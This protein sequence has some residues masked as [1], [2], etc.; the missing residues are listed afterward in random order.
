[1]RADKGAVK[2]FIQLKLKDFLYFCIPKR[3]TE[4]K[5]GILIYSIFFTVMILAVS[6]SNSKNDKVNSDIVHNEATADG[7]ETGNGP[8]I[9]F[10]KTEHDFGDIMDGEKVEYAFKFTNTGNKDLVITSH[11]ATC[12]CTVPEYPKGAIAPGDGGVIKVAF[13]SKGKKGRNNKEIRISTN[14]SERDVTLTIKAN[15]IKP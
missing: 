10:E 11:S 7:D 14:A 3:K 9:S 2:E 5:P 1:L 15:V 12:G 6:C 8:K 13:N 4:M